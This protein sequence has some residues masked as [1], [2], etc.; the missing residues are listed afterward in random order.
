MSTF[1]KEQKHVVDEFKD[2]QTLMKIKTSSKTLNINNNQTSYSEHG[3]LL[4]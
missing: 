2:N 4:L 3:K 1:S